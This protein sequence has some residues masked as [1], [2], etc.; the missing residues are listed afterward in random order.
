MVLGK[1]IAFIAVLGVLAV[2]LIAVL[3]WAFGQVAAERS[4][5]AKVSTALD[6][7]NKLKQK[8]PSEEHLAA[9][10]KECEESEAEYANLKKLLLSWWDRGIYDETE[11]PRQ[12][13]LFLGN[14]QQLQRQIRAFAA[15]RKPEV[16]LA[17]D[18][19][20]LGFP[21]LANN[22]PPLEVTLEMLKQRSAMRDIILLL[23]HNGVQSIDSIAWL[24]PEG[25]GKLYSKYRISVSFTCKYPALAKFLENLVA[26]EKQPISGHGLLPRNYLVVEELSYSATDRKVAALGTTTTG[27]GGSTHPGVPHGPAY[28]EEVGWYPTTPKTTTA[29]TPAAETPSPTTT[30]APGSRVGREP[31]YNILTVTLTIAMVDFSEEITGK[32]EDIEKPKES[33]PAGGGEARNASNARP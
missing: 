30:S 12:P 26:V 15:S 27:S 3:V 7:I 18:V 10:K 2:V 24:G 1:N 6:E 19:G 22:A 16:L 29:K 13:T 9:V 5:K 25:G 33:E 20:N 8:Q 17:Q 14:L 28:P 11:S 32:I 23:I 31:N 21:E 4:V